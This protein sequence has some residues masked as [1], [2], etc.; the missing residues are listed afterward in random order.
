MNAK[1]YLR[2][3]GDGRY[4]LGGVVDP[5]PA[6]LVLDSAVMACDVE[7]DGFLYFKPAQG[8]NLDRILTS[9][10][11]FDIDTT[12][13]I[14]TRLLLQRHQDQLRSGVQADPDLVDQI[15]ARVPRYADTPAQR[16][17]LQ[18]VAREFPCGVPSRPNQEQLDRLQALYSAAVAELLAPDDT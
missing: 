10:K 4:L 3:L 8:A 2:D 11:D 16:L 1:I 17:A 7:L 5:W 18:I 15:R 13:D 14:D 12:L 6:N 9:I